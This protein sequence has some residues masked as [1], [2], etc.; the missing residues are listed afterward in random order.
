MNNVSLHFLHAIHTPEEAKKVREI[1]P[2]Q[3]TDAVGRAAIEQTRATS[4]DELFFFHGLYTA[5]E[6]A[7]IRSCQ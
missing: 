2:D 1:F 6:I 5:E 7:Y 3:R 4:D